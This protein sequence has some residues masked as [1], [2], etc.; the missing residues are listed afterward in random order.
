MVPARTEEYGQP[1][2]RLIEGWGD[3]LLAA[4]F[5]GLVLIQGLT[6]PDSSRERLLNVVA[7]L[8]VFAVL[9]MR[10]QFPLLPLVLVAIA[11]VA[12]FW[13]PESSD[14]EAYGFIGILA[15][16]TAAAHTTGV[17]TVVAGVLTVALTVTLMAADGESWN[18]GGVLFFSLLLGSPFLVG[19]LFRARRLRESALEEKTV[20]LARERD[21]RA[22]A[23]V[24]EERTRIARELHDVV[25][26]AV[27]VIVLQARG[28]R[29]LLDD[30]PEEARTAFDTI[31]RTGQQALG[32]MR[33]LLGALRAGDEL[34]ALAP[35]PSLSRL[36]ALVDD[37][38]RAGLPVEVR[39]E[40]E[41]RPLPPGI[42]VSAFRI[43][44]E[45]LTN[46]LRHAGP[47]RAI[48]ALRYDEDG[49]D[50]EVADDGTAPSSSNGDGAGHGLAGIRERVAVYGGDF[51][52]GRRPEGGYA[53]RARLPYAAER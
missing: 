8:V 43:V 19:R 4:A 12:T 45:A 17:A 42:D 2:R 13:I 26:H 50:V 37:V 33:R 49:I 48:V 23:A 39:I 38:M 5:A 10:R 35:Q 52:A 51:A 46:A 21:E 34:L 14:N 53:I 3:M 32:E 24:A 9:T 20:A 41:P 25:A 44:Q 40:G 18:V 47:A 31:E 16:Y 6:E 11:G 36:D 22:R 1:M 7:A 27:S 15:I 29:K 30:E 28:G